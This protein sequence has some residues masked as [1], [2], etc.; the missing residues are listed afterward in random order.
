GAY[1]LVL[2]R[3]SP[4]T[5]DSVI[6]DSLALGR[7]KVPIS[8]GGPVGLDTM[9]IVHRAPE[10]VDGGVEVCDGLYLGGE[11]ESLGR[12]VEADPESFRRHVRLFLGYAGWGAGQLEA[13]LTLGTW[14]PV[15]P[16]VPAVFESDPTRLW[17]HVVRRLG[18]S[19]EGFDHQ[20]PDPSW[21]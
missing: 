20:P 1:G 2:N 14:L 7:A 4:H 12:Y 13:E 6:D 15:P 5:T 16:D 8:L 19:T 11:F 3:V 21:N 9:Q 10:H 17:R 18:A